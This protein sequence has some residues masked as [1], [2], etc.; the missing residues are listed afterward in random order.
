MISGILRTHS[1]HMIDSHCHLADPQFNDDLDDVLQRAKH[2]GVTHMVT[3]ADSIPEGEKCLEIASAHPHIFCTIGVHPHH[4]KDWKKGDGDRIR[5]LIASS[6]KAKA[7]GEIG[8]DYHYNHSPQG[9]QRAVFLEQLT[10]ARELAI[11]AV[12]HC[13]EALNH[14]RGSGTGQAMKDLRTIIEEVEPLQLVIHC[15]TEKWEDVEWVVKLGHLLSFTGIATYPKSHDIHE[16]IKRCPLEQ[17]M[18][19]TDSPYLAPVPHRGKRNEPAYVA[20]VL[21]CV[22]KIKGVS[23]EE[24]DRVTSENAVKF[25]GLM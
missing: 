8:L 5:A 3:I 14:S 12:I 21:K 13:R 20:E 4:A 10:L 25:F 7:V 15:C 22:A 1:P 2:A 19:E 11:P 24:A 9:V 6:K 23:V 17:M 16:T 18:I